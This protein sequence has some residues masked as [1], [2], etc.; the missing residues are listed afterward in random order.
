[1]SVARRWSFPLL[2]LLIAAG[3][4][5]QGARAPAS[6]TGGSTAAP[7]GGGGATIGAA[8]SLTGTADPS[9]TTT[10]WAGWETRSSM[11]SGSRWGQ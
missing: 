7:A 10:T 5:D 4:K 2:L 3:C 11:P 9:S 8:L 1:M 6:S